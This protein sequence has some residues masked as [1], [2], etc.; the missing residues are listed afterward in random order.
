MTLGLLF[1]TLFF[2]LGLSKTFLYIINKTNPINLFTQNSLGNIPGFTQSLAVSKSLDIIEF[3]ILIALAL[4]LFALNF[5]VTKFRRNKGQIFDFTYLAVSLIFY[6]QATFV[7]FSGKILLIFFGLFQVIFWF[8]LLK[9]SKNSKIDFDKHLFMNGILL[10]LVLMQIVSRFNYSLFLVWG[11]LAVTPLIYHLISNKFLKSPLHVIL[12]LFVLFPG[13]LNW[14]LILLFVTGLLIIATHLRKTKITKNITE[15]TAKLYPYVLITIVIFNPL[16]Y[17]SHLDTVEE[18]FWLGWLYRLINGQD[19]YKD[20]LVY[21][22]PLLVWGLDVFTKIFGLSVANVKLYFHLLQIISFFIFYKVIKLLVSSK[23]GQSIVLLMLMALSVNIVKN[24]AEI[25][26]A[27]GLLALVPLFSY[28]KHNQNK[29]L[30]L[31]GIISG[32]S[33]F[34]SLEVGMVA[35]ASISLYLLLNRGIKATKNLFVYFGGVGFISLII[36]GII[37][38]QGA[39]PGM[40]DQLNF[41]VKAF[42]EGY[43]N[44]ALP[45]SE[46]FPLLDWRFLNSYLGSLNFWWEFGQIIIMVSL[47]WSFFCYFWSDNKKNPAD[48]V[49]LVISLFGLLIF[50]S[51]LGRTDW[52]HLLFPLTISLILLGY[53][54]NSSKKFTSTLFILVFALYSFGFH[55]DAFNN[56]FVYGQV[57]KFQSYGRI[58]GS[59]KQY[60]SPKFGLSLDQGFNTAPTDALI[61]YLSATDKNQKIFS[62]PWMPEIYLLADRQNATSVDTPYAFFTPKY[63]K[64]IIDQL[65]AN[66]KTLIIYNP[67][68]G[69]GGMSKES[70]EMVHN[71]ILENTQEVT[72][73]DRIEIR[74]IISN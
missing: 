59:S 5:F 8:S 3:G 64:Q 71:F 13:N 41:Y 18:G 58:P 73:F 2:S 42:S 43:F 28:L 65:L 69:F 36:V 27:V 19:L 21:H 66:P 10:G 46:L 38:V 47:F 67:E 29:W 54:I 49:G 15:F 61:D 4:I 62:Y 30:F 34:T 1:G 55:R 14:I 22:P 25:R 23:F 26:L 33:I 24:N 35:V 68:L 12:G 37:F 11:T 39:L 44:K 50:R 31:S 53:L 45:R 48:A 70:L 17:W 74:Q 6:L 9:K 56:Y 20:V 32:L 52:Y 60:K 16:Y 51:S 40:W 63:Q 57:E 7:G 72:K